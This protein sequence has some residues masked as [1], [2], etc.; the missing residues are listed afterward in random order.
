MGS[1]MDNGDKTFVTSMLHD[2]KHNAE[3]WFGGKSRRFGNSNQS[4]TM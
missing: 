2:R 4:K 1:A 3:G